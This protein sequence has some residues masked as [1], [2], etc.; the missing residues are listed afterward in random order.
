MHVQ[1]LAALFEKLHSRDADTAVREELLSERLVS[2]GIALPPSC[3]T[4]APLS[5]TQ[6]PEALSPGH[7]AAAEPANY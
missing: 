5:Q 2:A 3:L 7:H 4:Q 6:P 1:V